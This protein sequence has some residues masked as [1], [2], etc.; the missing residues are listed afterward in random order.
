M[1]ES[2]TR[3]RYDPQAVAA[4]GEAYLPGAV[5]PVE[6]R[7]EGVGARR[8][9]S[10]FDGEEW[11][12]E[13]EDE[14]RWYRLMCARDFRNV[15][16]AMH[17]KGLSDGR[18]WTPHT[19]TT[20]GDRG[21]IKCEV[22]VRPP[23]DPAIPLS[24]VRLQADLPDTSPA[25]LFR[26]LQEH[27]YRATWDA[28]M[29]RGYNITQ[30]SRNNDIG[31]YQMKFG[32]GMS[33]RDFCNQRGWADLGGDEYMI[34]N[35]GVPHANCPP[36]KGVVRGQ[37]FMSA[38]YL[39]PLSK[40]G[41]C[42]AVYLT[43]S[44]PKGSLPS[45]LVNWFMKR[46][47]PE[48]AVKL[49]KAEREM[50]EWLHK[51][52]HESIRG[53]Q[54]VSGP[55]DETGSKPGWYK[56]AQPDDTSAWAC[57]KLRLDGVSEQIRD[58][59]EKESLKRARNEQREADRRAQLLRYSPGAFPMPL[60]P[61]TFPATP[62]TPVRLSTDELDSGV[63]IAARAASFSPPPAARFVGAAAPTA[64]DYA[65]A[66]ICTPASP[67]PVAAAAVSTSTDYAAAPT[68]TDYAAAPTGADYAAAPT[69]VDHAAS[70]QPVAVG[71]GVTTCAVPAFT[72]IVAAVEVAAAQTAATAVATPGCAPTADSTGGIRATG[73]VSQ[74]VSQRD[75][76]TR[77]VVQRDV[78][79]Q[80]RTPSPASHTGFWRPASSVGTWADDRSI[81]EQGPWMRT[82]TLDHGPSRGME[83]RSLASVF[84]GECGL[85]KS[86]AGENGPP[87]GTP[88]EHSGPRG[89]GPQRSNS[90][91]GEY[92]PRGTQPPR[93]PPRSPPPPRCSPTTEHPPSSPPPLRI[94]PTLQHQPPRSPP[95][96]LEY[97]PPRPPPHLQ[98]GSSRSAPPAEHGR[99]RSE[100][101]FAPYPQSSG[102]QAP[103]SY[104]YERLPYERLPA[105]WGGSNVSQ[106]QSSVSQLQSAVSQLQSTVSQLQSTVSQQQAAPCSPVSPLSPYSSPS[107]SHLKWSSDAGENFPSTGVAKPRGYSGELSPT[108]RSHALEQVRLE[109]RR[110]REA[111][112]L[113]RQHSVPP[114]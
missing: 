91:S 89:F 57:C 59:A 38:Y 54:P 4:R 101:S 44:D 12:W 78:G 35:R 1:V 51:M 69:A 88:F 100:R 9:R 41:G 20:R 34:A 68:G 32:Y 49:Q 36:Y 71:T 108:S 28:V 3:L 45:M 10:N 11:G 112:A 93:H 56:P 98:N 111:L 110:R 15:Q 107:F 27:A 102:Q 66:P 14:G 29:V 24:E 94:S 106:Q 18:D 67:Q 113:R 31:Y 104:S 58:I 42:R 30:L 17:V 13:C 73:V 23:A 43:C 79:N 90:P 82:P 25:G 16:R 60:T 76:V 6:V 46:A 7:D 97:A 77:D 8:Y 37:S 52:W 96:S 19:S 61:V 85:P 84:P 65:A 50:V 62:S 87:R 80:R 109:T 74:D 103:G 99:S 40:D 33:N 75:T 39:S 95:P 105:V 92:A 47:A 81:A 72:D 26:L 63:P 114:V 2:R 22:K 86:S 5:G 55:W 70:P 48:T 21:E 83:E 64:A 53:K